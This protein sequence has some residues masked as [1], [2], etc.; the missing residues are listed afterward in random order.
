MNK[1]YLLLLFFKLSI[2][3]TLESC[4]KE[5]D[6]VMIIPSPPSQPSNT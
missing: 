3:F 5:D 1:L 2:F 6:G 4:E